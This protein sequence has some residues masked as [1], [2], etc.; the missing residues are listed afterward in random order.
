MTN[1]TD[2]GAVVITGASTGI[3]KACALRL[4][5]LGFRVFAGVR[6]EQDGAA[7]RAEASERLS[8]LHIDVTEQRSIDDAAETVTTALGG[9]LAGLVNNAGIGVGGP[10][11]FLALDRIREQFEV[12]LFGQIAVTQAFLALI[13]KGQGRIVN[14]GSIAGRVAGPIIGPYSASKFALEAVTDSLRLELTPW[15][16]HVCIVEPGNIDT[17]I[18]GKARDMVDRMDE[19]FSEEA[20]ALYGPIL[21]QMRGWVES[22]AQAGIDA[23]EVAKA[24]EHAL[25]AKRPK[26]RYLVGNDAKQQ[27]FIA[28]WLPDRM[29]N[30][31][32]RRELGIQD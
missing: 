2:R 1:E 5:R 10:L 28:R 18:W 7:L 32:I 17:P 3:G 30:W 20:L 29:R 9:G 12:N 14:M 16:I 8:P 22:S 26:T 4:D 19:E 13:R 23:D 6:R 25:T 27:A 15:K 11:E 21:E 24:V 31:L